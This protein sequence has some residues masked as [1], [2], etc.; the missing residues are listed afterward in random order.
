MTDRRAERDRE[1]RE[2]RKARE[3]EERRREE[4]NRQR[5]RRFEELREAW[6]RNHPGE[7]KGGKGRAGAAGVSDA[8]LATTPPEADEPRGAGREPAPKTQRR[9]P[10]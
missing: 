3:A 7:E 5:K 10:A 8:P 1:R 2:R 9:R 6:L 4:W